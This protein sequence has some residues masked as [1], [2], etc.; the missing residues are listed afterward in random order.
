MVAATSSASDQVRSAQT[1]DK[2]LDAGIALFSSLGFEA[3]STRQVETHAGVQRNLINYHFGSKENFWKACM[4]VLFDPMVAAT[5]EVVALSRDLPS[6][7]RVRFLIRRYVRVSAAHPEITR[8][9]FDEGRR[10]DWRLAWL[11]EN[12]SRDFYETVGRLFEMGRDENILPDI[13]LSQFYYALVSSTV[14]FAMAPECRM[15]SGQ[16]PNSDSL[17]DAQADA[18]AG[19]LTVSRETQP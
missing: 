19:L 18:I 9:M 12:Y 7:E 11:V 1:Q 6:A 14:I 2:L 17:V 13:S 4:N 5:R 10:D 8:I 16:D 3:T 15:L